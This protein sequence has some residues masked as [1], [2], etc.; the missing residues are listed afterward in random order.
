VGKT[1]YFDEP[2]LLL[3]SNHLTRIRVDNSLILPRFLAI[4]IHMKWK[5]GVFRN[6]ITQWV[7]Q[8]AI[9]QAQLKQLPVALP[10]VS[11]QRRIIEILDQADRLRKLRSEADS[12]AERILPSLFLEF[13]GDPIEN[14][15]GWGTVP[16]GQAGILERGVSRHRPR[17]DPSLL[18][19]PYPFIQ[20]GEVTNCGG[21]IYSYTY[22]YSELG[23]QQSRLWSAGTLC[24]TIAA[25]IAQTGILELDACFPDS[26]VGFLPHDRGT[27]EFIQAWLGFLQPTI[28]AKAPGFAQKNINLALLREL[29]VILPP[30]KLRERFSEQARI[31]QFQRRL[32]SRAA[33]LLSDL[34]TALLHRAFTGDLTA[35]WREAHMNELLQEMEHEEKALASPEAIR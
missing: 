26:V 18:G 34:F 5:Q 23:L 30:R 11:E 7:N 9:S 27:T 4:Y 33:E 16:F 12:T 8:A 1:A 22:T 13:F 32:R 17:N 2:G 15:K 3:F 25:N 19:G 20:T 21:R 31:L 14:P 29:P 10:P 24:I 6:S 28:E 35:S